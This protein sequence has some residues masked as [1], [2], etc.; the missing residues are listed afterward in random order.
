MQ[1][2]REYIAGKLK[3]CP[4]CGKGL[5]RHPIALVPACFLHG[6]F[7]LTELDGNVTIEFKLLRWP[8]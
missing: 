6:D 2:A 5:E 3:F 8:R 4:V 7:K 1:Y